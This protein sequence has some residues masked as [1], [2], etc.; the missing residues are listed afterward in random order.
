VQRYTVSEVPKNMDVATKK[1]RFYSLIVPSVQKVHD[2]LMDE[3]L[4]V[5]QN[6]EEKKDI[7]EIEKLKKLYKAKSDEELLYALKPHPQS[8]VLAQAAIESAWGT[9]RFFREANNVFGIWSVNKNEPRIAA[10]EKRSNGKTVWLRKF[11]SVEDSMRAYYKLMARG[12]AFKEFR[13]LRYNSDDVHKI[14][15]KLDKYSEIGELYGKEL[16]QVIKHN[17]LI[18]HDR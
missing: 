3:Y 4:R 8:I 17:R 10:G 7:D 11:A 14:V 13:K 9:S 5:E 6:I 18:K 1:K 16:S 15:Q 12:K 2:E